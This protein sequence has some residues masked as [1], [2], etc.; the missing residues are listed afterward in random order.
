MNV[1]LN[2][3]WIAALSLSIVLAACGGGGSSNSSSGGTGTATGAPV[4]LWTWEGGSNLVNAVGAYGALQVAASGNVPGAREGAAAWTD[5]AGNFWMF[6]GYGNDSAGNPI[7]Y[8]NDLWKFNPSLN[9]WEWMGGANAYA[10]AGTYGAEGTPLTTNIPGARSNASTWTDKSGKLWLF[11]GYG[12]DAAGT[13]GNL[14]DLWVYD[15]VALTWEWV[16]GGETVATSTAVYG[17]VNTPGATF[18]PGGRSGAVSWTDTAGH[19]WLAGGNGLDSTNTTGYLA[20]LWEFNIALN[21]W[22]YMGG[23]TT[24]NAAG[25]YGT[26]AI[27]AAGNYPGGRSSAVSWRDTSDNLWLFGGYGYDSTQTLGTLNDLWRFDPATLKW[28]WM[29]GDNLVNSTGSY[30]TEGTVVSTN[31]PAARVGAVAWTDSSGNFWLFGGSYSSGN[32]FN[33]LW[34]YSPSAGTWAWQNGTNVAN[35]PG[36]YG[37]LGTGSSSVI[38]GA[39]QNAVAWRATNGHLYLFGGVGIDADDDSP[40]V[41]NDMWSYTP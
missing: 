7:N 41:M 38:I 36:T 17:A 1:R 6:G 12:Y 18:Q 24:A 9:E 33:D 13:I 11:G 31:A 32:Y 20:D 4:G 3:G 19:L 37:T 15:P 30:G 26:R 25:V 8:L 22:A 10:T 5:H 16:A 39:H 27:A 34:E 21:E 2:S 28:I 23:I 29:S 40:N 14:N 35:Y